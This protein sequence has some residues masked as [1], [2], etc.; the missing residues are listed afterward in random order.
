MEPF[1]IEGHAVALYERAGY[2]PSKP[3]D[4]TRI[5]LALPEF[6]VEFATDMKRA[7]QIVSAGAGRWSL[8][9]RQSATPL[10]RRWLA[11]HELGESV[12]VGTRTHSEYIE[13]YA[14]NIGA[15]LCVP[16]PAMHALRHSIGP[17]FIALAAHTKLTQTILALRWGEVFG[18]AVAILMPGRVKRVGHMPPDHELRKIAKAGGCRSVRAIRFTD[19]SRI[20]LVVQD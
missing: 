1:E 3:V 18:S 6:D 11:G 8:R 20:A 12:L 15:A 5:A 7:A 14:N 16:R 10:Q 9:I 4:P 19:S 13:T 2:D 17:D